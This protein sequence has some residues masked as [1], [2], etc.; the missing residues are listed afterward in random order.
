MGE[1]G[2]DQP[3][4]LVSAC[5]V[6]QPMG[7]PVR[8]TFALM[9]LQKGK[10]ILTDNNIPHGQ[11]VICLYGF[12]VGMCLLALHADWEVEARERGAW[13]LELGVLVTGTRVCLSSPLAPHPAEREPS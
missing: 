8:K 2:S 3:Q 13:H 11:C 1:F 9:F 10:E 7:R 4:T 12:Q 5:R 6:G